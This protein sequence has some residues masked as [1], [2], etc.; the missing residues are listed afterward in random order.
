[1]HD[2]L[3]VTRPTSLPLDHHQTIERV[4]ILL[5]TVPKN[6]VIRKIPHLQN[7]CGR[8]FFEFCN[9]YRW[10][11]RQHMVSNV[12]CHILFLLHKYGLLLIFQ[13]ITVLKQ[14]AKHAKT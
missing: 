9:S 14:S 1:M 6:N 4:R 7:N 10:R 8:F 2:P 13:C 5:L 3:I 11:F 12:F